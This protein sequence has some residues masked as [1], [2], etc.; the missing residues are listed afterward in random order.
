MLFKTRALFET[1]LPLSL[2][3]SVFFCWP[4]FIG[5]ECK[6]S[7]TFGDP[8]DD[9]DFSKKA[10][11][12]WFNKRSSRVS[13]TLLSTLSLSLYATSAT[14]AEAVPEKVDVVRGAGISIVVACSIVPDVIKFG[15][16]KLLI[17][18]RFNTSGSSL[19]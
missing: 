8:L 19:S 17:S 18:P 5:V 6:C 11:A 9:K 3:I 7:S 15:S 10:S 4:L 13:I 16:T 1:G 12:P 14:A 2:F